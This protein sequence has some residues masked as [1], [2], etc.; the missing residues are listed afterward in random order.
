MLMNCGIWTR[1]KLKYLK[2]KR[3]ASTQSSACSTYL[4]KGEEKERWRPNKESTSLKDMLSHVALHAS[5][6]HDDRKN[7]TEEVEK[8]E[9]RKLYTHLYK[10]D[11]ACWGP[12]CRRSS[13]CLYFR[14][15]K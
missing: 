4:L 2:S 5:T 7:E 11:K 12:P 8:E 14:V 13:K 9:I 10:E 1:I 6:N 15:S 3:I